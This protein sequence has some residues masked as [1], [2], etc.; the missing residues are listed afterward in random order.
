MYPIFVFVKRN[1]ENL[2]LTLKIV[3]PLLIQKSIESQAGKVKSMQRKTDFGGNVFKG[4][5]R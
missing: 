3:I 4:S 5:S 2:S 1:E